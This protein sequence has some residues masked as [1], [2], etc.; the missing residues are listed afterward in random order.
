VHDLGNQLKLLSTYETFVNAAGV[1]D[2]FEQEGETKMIAYLGENS[3]EVK[4]HWK[5][6]LPLVVK[7]YYGPT[8]CIALSKDGKRLATAPAVG[9][10]IEVFDTKSGERLDYLYRGAGQATIFSLCFSEDNSYL[11]A[12]SNSGTAHLFELGKAQAWYSLTQATAS[13][14]KFK[15]LPSV[16]TKCVIDSN[17]H[18]TCVCIDNLYYRYN[19]DLTSHAIQALSESSS[20]I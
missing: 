18:L 8:M 2:V 19:F 12:N 9:T 14:L 20:L 4:L 6:Q 10:Y 13:S 16:F 7:P 1:L 15:D 17:N 11:I 3:G 5:D